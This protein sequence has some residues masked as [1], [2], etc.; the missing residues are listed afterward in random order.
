[1]GVAN[2]PAKNKYGYHINGKLGYGYDEW[3]KTAHYFEGSWWITWSDK[4]KKKSGKQ[5]PSPKL[6]GNKKH[7]EIEPAPGRYVKE[8]C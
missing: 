8:K 1:M 5:I 3:K 4:L 7:K 2:P 6:L